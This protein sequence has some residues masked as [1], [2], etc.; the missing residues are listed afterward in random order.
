MGVLN[1]DPILEDLVLGNVHL[2]LLSP[3]E[4]EHY[5]SLVTVESIE[6]QHKS[7]NRFE[8][9]NYSILNERVYPNFQDGGLNQRNATKLQQLID[10]DPSLKNN[11]MNLFN[12]DFSP[13]LADDADLLGLP[14]AFFI[15][16]GQDCR[17]DECLVYAQRLKRLNSNVDIDYYENATHGCFAINNGQAERMK[18]SIHNYLG[19]NMQT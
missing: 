17:K 12:P 16:S 15:V 14:P 7:K 10:K 4:R 6:D 18:N 13:L 9:D 19:N 1:V 8:Y 11:L 2:S 5:R 3:Q